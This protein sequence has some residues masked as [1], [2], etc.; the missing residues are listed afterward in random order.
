MDLFREK[1]SSGRSPIHDYFP[2]YEGGSTDVL[3]AQE[4]FT[5]KFK[6]L[7]RSPTQQFYVHYMDM[8]DLEQVRD[9]MK[10]VQDVIVQEQLYI[11][12]PSEQ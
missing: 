10:A 9:A 5:E 12:C 1:I 11:S 4:F 6:S 3:A 7:V 8:T 2:D